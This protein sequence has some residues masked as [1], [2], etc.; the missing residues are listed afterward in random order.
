LIRPPNTKEIKKHSQESDPA[1]SQ[2]HSELP[3]ESKEAT[4]SLKHQG[5]NLSSIY[6]DNK[7]KNISLLDISIISPARFYSGQSSHSV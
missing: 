2:I 5:S 7:R 4:I 6:K 3:V 1:I